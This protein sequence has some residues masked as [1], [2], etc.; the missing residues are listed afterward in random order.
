[1]SWDWSSEKWMDD[2]RKIPDETMSY[3][4]KLAIHAVEKSGLSV[5]E[6][7]RVFNVEPPVIYAW[8]HKYRLGGLEALETRVAKGAEAKITPDMEEWLKKA[9]LEQTPE[10]YGYDT[11]LWTRGILAE[12]LRRRF[13]LYVA[14]STVNLHL[15]KLGLSYQKPAYVA[16]EQDPDEVKYFLEV[17]FPKIQRLAKKLGAD[18]L[19]QDEAGV[20]IRT[21]YGYTWGEK[22][23]TP[24]VRVTDKRGGFNL[25]S[26]V[27]AKGKLLYSIQDKTINSEVY[28][29]FLKQLIRSSSCTLILIIDRARFHS[30]KDVRDFVRSHRTA[31]RVFFLPRYAPQLNPSEQVW[32]EIKCN[33]IGK[34]RIENKADLR[35]RLYLTMRSLQKI[36]GR[37]KSFFMLDETCYANIDE[38]NLI[39]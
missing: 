10:D 6:I 4:R 17:K 31:L 38:G 7:S 34:Q 39:S 28:I 8:L 24:K 19:F 22:G 37:I 21:R 27:S 11:V 12:L 36:T 29:E 15:K 25:L 3:I 9:V 1:M 35:E 2:G 30:S 26:A 20:G 23:K 14:D 13:H 18:I 33:K 5:E 16:H 32:G